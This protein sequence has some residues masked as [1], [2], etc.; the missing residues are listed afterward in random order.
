MSG[1]YIHFPDRAKK[2]RSQHCYISG[3]A[4]FGSAECTDDA[5]TCHMLERMRQER[6]SL[7]EPI[8][9]RSHK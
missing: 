3:C 9:R 6:S 2:R 8:K 5:T 1:T 7:F 4:K